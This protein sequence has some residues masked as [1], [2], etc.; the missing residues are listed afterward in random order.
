M[1]SGWL[2]SKTKAG[3]D[4]HIVTRSRPIKPNKPDTEWHCSYVFHSTDVAGARLSTARGPWLCP[5]ARYTFSP[6]VFNVSLDIILNIQRY[7]SRLLL[8][9][10]RTYSIIRTR[11]THIPSFAVQ[12]W[13]S[14]LS[15]ARGSAV[16]SKSKAFLACSPDIE[17]PN[18]HR[19]LIAST[20]P[21]GCT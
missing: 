14:P 19:L 1:R 2:K 8:T 11:Q 16:V 6:K 12:R 3:Y 9:L 10:S 5:K 17:S 13:P 4:F 21:R 15:A 20:R 7:F 18:T